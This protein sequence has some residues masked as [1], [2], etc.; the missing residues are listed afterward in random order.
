MKSPSFNSPCLIF[1]LGAKQPLLAGWLH[2]WQV[3]KIGAEMDASLSAEVSCTLARHACRTRRLPLAQ[4]EKDVQ[5]N[6]VRCHGRGAWCAMQGRLFRLDALGQRLVESGL[7]NKRRVCFS[8]PAPVGGPKC[9]L[10]P[11]VLQR[12]GPKRDD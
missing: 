2:C 8:A 10:P 9:Y 11:E 6:Q 3:A 12:A 4:V 5:Q 1:A 7:V